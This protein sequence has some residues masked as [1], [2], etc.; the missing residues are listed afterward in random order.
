MRTV[1]LWNGRLRFRRFD[2]LTRHR[3]SLRC[4]IAVKSPLHIPSPRGALH[5]ADRCPVAVLVA[6]AAGAP[7][8][9]RTPEFAAQSRALEVTVTYQGGEVSAANAIY[10]SVFDTPNMQGWKRCRSRR[11]S[12][13]RT[14]GPRRSPTSPPR[15]CM[16]RC[17]M[18]S[19]VA[20]MGC[21]RF[22]PAR[23]P[24]PVHGR[25]ICSRSDRTDRGGKR[26]AGD[27][28]QR[29]VQDALRPPVRRRAPA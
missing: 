28:L 2:T 5:E 13:R 3:W 10:V 25:K 12:S 19:G 15:R 17:S 23:W 29:R 8:Q 20:G 14:A 6:L 26:D 9:A 16:W 21:P 4:P 24:L 7:L 18:T 27:H 22:P 11:R 1:G